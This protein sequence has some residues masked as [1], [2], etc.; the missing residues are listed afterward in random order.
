M[1]PLYGV[2][3]FPLAI[4]SAQISEREAIDVTA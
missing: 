2:T 4:P 1:C 3:V